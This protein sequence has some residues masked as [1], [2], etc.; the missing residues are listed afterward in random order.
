[1]PQNTDMDSPVVIVEDSEMSLR[2]LESAVEAVTGLAL[3]GTARSPA[4]AI[5][6]VSTLRPA[7]VI[8]DL[9]LADGSGVDVLR[10]MAEKGIRA[11]VVVVTNAPSAALGDA[12]REFGARFF[13]DK[14]LE[15]EEFQAALQTLQ[16]EIAGG[17]VSV[18]CGASRL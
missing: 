18:K 5:E 16:A 3:A 6:L 4:E 10:A 7:I 2:R 17:T 11:E 9:F 8:L 12:C 1:V 14:T 13:F 15:F